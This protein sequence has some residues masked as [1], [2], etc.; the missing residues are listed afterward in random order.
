[1]NYKKAVLAF[2]LLLVPSALLQAQ[3]VHRTFLGCTFGDKM[4]T[5]LVSLGSRFAHL[6]S[7][8]DAI[9]IEAEKNLIEY[10]GVRWKH[11]YLSFF[12]NQ[13]YSITFTNDDT[14]H[15]RAQI[16]QDYTT[17]RADFSRRFKDYLLYNV[18]DGLRV[19]DGHTGIFCHT[20]CVDEEG[21]RCAP[22]V[23]TVRLFLTY[24]DEKI[25]QVK[26]MLEE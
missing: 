12:D 10:N 13:F 26:R 6:T 3:Q 21:N 9:V 15:H 22:E 19:H 25:D 20:D 11:V 24:T 18:D 8:K 7:C 2:L 14:H 5:V 16:R 4:D 17:M 23:G 1:M